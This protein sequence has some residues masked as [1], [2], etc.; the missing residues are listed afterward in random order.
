MM[1]SGLTS[2]MYIKGEQEVPCPDPEAGLYIRTRSGGIVRALI[3][4]DQLAFQVGQ[5]LSIASGG[6]LRATP[7]CVRAA[8]P[9]KCIGGWSKGEREREVAG[10]RR[11][12]KG[13][14][15]WGRETER[16]ERGWLGVGR[17]TF[18]AGGE[19]RWV[20]GVGGQGRRDGVAGKDVQAGG[21]KGF[22]RVALRKATPHALPQAE[23]AQGQDRRP[24]PR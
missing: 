21:T 1:L 2:A 22:K 19:C 8:A 9:E 16:A 4:A 6:M 13:S 5:A 10:V 20:G 11:R 23:N 17:G 15:W 3:P 7:H 18:M 12:K 14:E 24:F